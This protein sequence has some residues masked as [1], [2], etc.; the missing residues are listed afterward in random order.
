MLIVSTQGLLNKSL[1]LNNLVNQVNEK[2]NPYIA[3]AITQKIVSCHFNFSTLATA[4]F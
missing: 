1:N 2:K 4:T 3:I